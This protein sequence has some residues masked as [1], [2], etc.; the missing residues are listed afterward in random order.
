LITGGSAGLGLALATEFVNAGYTVYSC[1]RNPSQLHDAAD[2]LPGLRT[3][4]ADVTDPADRARLFATVEAAGDSLDIL[5]NNA[6]TTNAHDYTN[7]VTLNTDRARRE[8]ELNF[9]APIELCR[10]FLA[11][12]RHHGRDELPGSLVIVSTPAALIPMEAQPLY[13]ATKAGLHMFTLTLRLNLQG[14]AVRVVEVF[15]PRMETGLLGD[16]DLAGSSTSAGR[17]GD[18]AE[19]I[20]GDI[21]A[22]VEISLPHASSRSLYNGIPV[23]EPGFVERVNAGVKRRPGWDSES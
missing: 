2:A 8:I 21:V 18:V 15:P 6:A 11:A 16:L 9:A 22:G 7:D 19:A 10:L 12:R 20:F 23:P 14:T 13:C 1:A 4:V 5:V 3:I 17:V